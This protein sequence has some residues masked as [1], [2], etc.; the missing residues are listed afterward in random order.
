MDLLNGKDE[1]TELQNI[2]AKRHSGCPPQNS[3]LDPLI[4]RAWTLQ[5]TLLSPRILHFFNSA[6]VWQCN[7][8][9][10]IPGGTNSRPSW[11]QLLQK[12]SMLGTEPLA[13]WK[14]IVE[15]YSGRNLTFEIDKF[16]VLSGIA[17]K[18][19]EIIHSKYLAGLWERDIAR[20]LY[21]QITDFGPIISSYIA[22]SW[23][24]ASVNGRISFFMADKAEKVAQHKYKPNVESRAVQ[25]EAK[26]SN[27]FVD[28][29]NGY[30]EVICLLGKATLICEDPRSEEGYK[31]SGLY[32]RAL[33]QRHKVRLN[34]FT[35]DPSI[36]INFIQIVRSP[37]AR[38]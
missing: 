33:T 31:I 32:E 7:K 36:S 24:W 18:V 8:A 13:F 2:Y 1:N 30:A 29:M 12:T 10:A 4:T 22:P 15:D 28:V 26:G 37:A 19:S 14:T 23:S 20:Q 17:E 34:D 5:E 38:A 25:C 3:S 16:H 11:P 27:Q 9:A 35:W 21:W 6:L